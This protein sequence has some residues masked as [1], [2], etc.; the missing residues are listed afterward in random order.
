MEIV[1]DT[2]EQSIQVGIET[3]HLGP[4]SLVVYHPR[5]TDASKKRIK[6][7]VRQPDGTL[8]EFEADRNDDRAGL[9]LDV[10]CQYS[11]AEIEMF[12]HREFCIQQKMGELNERAIEDRRIAAEREETFQAKAKA[13]AMPQIRDH[14][15]PQVRRDIRRAHS[16]FEVM[17]LTVAAISPANFTTVPTEGNA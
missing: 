11:E 10:F 4:D 17:A 16:A 12:T 8:V 14:Q 7:I 9:I 1:K 3:I 2:A 13:L 5:Y 15:N 6:A